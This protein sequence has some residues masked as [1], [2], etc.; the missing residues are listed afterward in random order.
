MCSPTEND[1]FLG[2]GGM[3]FRRLNDEQLWFLR[4]APCLLLVIFAGTLNHGLAHLSSE[5][6]NVDLLL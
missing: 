3:K 6:S 5:G 2:P 1:C 4:T